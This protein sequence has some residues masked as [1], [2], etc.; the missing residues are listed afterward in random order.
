[1]D[2]NVGKYNTSRTEQ[3]VFVDMKMDDLHICLS[4]VDIVVMIDLPQTREKLE[5]VE[6]YFQVNIYIMPLLIEIE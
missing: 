6:S 5:D 2:D 1:M 3:Y 4:A